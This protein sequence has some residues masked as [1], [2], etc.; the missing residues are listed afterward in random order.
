MNVTIFRFRIADGAAREFFTA[1]QRMNELAATMPG[2]VAHKAFR[3]EDGEF[4][5]HIEFEDEETMRAWGRHPEHLKAK[6]DGRKTFFSEYR[7]QVC[8][9]IR[10][11]KSK[12]QAS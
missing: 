11:S 2:Y 6:A 12:S 5:I 8:D 3:A 9:L 4:L 1:V 7:T 10:E